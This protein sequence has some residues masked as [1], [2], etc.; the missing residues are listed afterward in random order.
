MTTLT[1]RLSRGFNS[2]AA[3]AAASNAAVVS[4]SD[5][6]MLPGVTATVVLKQLPVSA[7]KLEQGNSTGSSGLNTQAAGSSSSSYVGVGC[8]GSPRAA[9]G[10]NMLSSTAAA[11]GGPCHTLQYSCTAAPAAA[12]AAAVS[13]LAAAADSRVASLTPVHAMAADSA[14]EL[15]RYGAVNASSGCGNPGH[16]CQLRSAAAAAAGRYCQLWC[17]RRWQCY[18]VQQ[19]RN[20]PDAWQ[21]LQQ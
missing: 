19:Q 10:L 20:N 18:A 6:H 2:P 16:A 15:H 1:R 8:E 4:G 7:C 21:G 3:A 13:R 11:A 9:A 14:I 17:C 5:P 12:A